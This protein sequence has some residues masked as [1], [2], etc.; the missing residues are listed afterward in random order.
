MDI[1]ITIPKTTTWEEYQK[2]LDLAESGEYYLNYQTARF[3]KHAHVGD[4]CYVVHRGK[5]KGYMLISGFSNKPFTCTVTGKKYKGNF[6]QRTGKF[7]KVKEIPK[8][9]FR[10][11]RYFGV[12]INDTSGVKINDKP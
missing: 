2:E 7:Y 8:K 6:I 1:I 4:R 12:S 5:L 3:P 9:S 10:S 11:F